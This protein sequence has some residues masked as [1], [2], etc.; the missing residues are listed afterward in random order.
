MSASL[1][2]CF[3]CHWGRSFKKR[4]LSDVVDILNFIKILLTAREYEVHP[5]FSQKSR[6]G[7]A[8]ATTEDGPT[9]KMRCREVHL[10]VLVMNPMIVGSLI[11]PESDQSESLFYLN[12][13]GP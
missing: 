4:S 7:E 10:I 12:E 3:V 2:F 5:L 6:A 9:M 1:D 8:A 13:Q 11:S